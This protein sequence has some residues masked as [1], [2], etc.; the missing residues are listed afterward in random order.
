MGI[1]KWQ[2]CTSDQPDGYGS[3]CVDIVD[4]N[5]ANYQIREADLNYRLRVVVTAT[6]DYG[7]GTAAPSKV[8][9]PVTPAPPSADPTPPP[10]PPPGI[11]APEIKV[12][13]FLSGSTWTYGVELASRCE[14]QL[15]GGGIQAFTPSL[16]GQYSVTAGNGNQ[17]GQLK[18]WNGNVGPVT[19]SWAGPSAP[20]PPPPDPGISAP[21]IILWKFNTGNSWSYNVSNANYCEVVLAGGGVQP[22]SPS[23]G[24]QFSVTAGNG[25]QA[26]QLKCWNSSVGPAISAFDGPAAPT[27]VDPPPP[28]LPGPKPLPDQY[29]VI[30][31]KSIIGE[32]LFASSGSWRFSVNSFTYQ[33]YRCGGTD[34]L[35]YGINC[36]A[37][38]FAKNTSY[39]IDASDKGQRIVVK[40][41]ATNANGSVSVGSLATAVVT[42]GRAQISAVPAGVVAAGTTVSLNW[43]MSPA[44]RCNLSSNPAVANWNGKTNQPA[45]GSATVKVT[46][47]TVFGWGC[48]NAQNFYIGDY[49]VVVDNQQ[50]PT[51][52]PPPPPPPGNPPAPQPNL[53]VNI[54]AQPGT[55]VVAGTPVS[56]VWNSTNATSCTATSSP[57]NP[58]W[59]GSKPASGNQAVGALTATTSFNISCNGP[60]GFVLGSV[61]VTIGAAPADAFSLNSP[62]LRRVGASPGGGGGGTVAVLDTG[63]EAHPL[64]NV[65]GGFNCVAGDG[66]PAGQDDNGHGTSVAGVIGA[67]GDG[68]STPRGIAPGAAIISIKMAGASG[69]SNFDDIL[70]AIREG[71]ARAGTL[72]ISSSIGRLIING[73][74]ETNLSSC[75]S[76]IL[77]QTI[78]NARVRIVAAAGNSPNL[79]TLENSF[80]R[81]PE[82]TA[83]TAMHDN[84]GRPGALGS[85]T[86]GPSNCTGDDQIA[87]YSSFYN[88]MGGVIAAPG[89]VFTTARGGGMSRGSGGTSHATPMVAGSSGNASSDPAYMY[90]P[91]PTNRD[92]GPLLRL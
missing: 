91:P 49:T 16:G 80:G 75:D 46:E 12:W 64:L 31:G 85:A 26:G 81:Y 35:G 83:V 24:G 2:R 73:E 86:G 36:V 76:S 28:P 59:S 65:T 17:A 6:N 44:T 58:Q 47:T 11:P 62:H 78:C 79:G 52:P 68:I 18:C 37:I 55:T 67:S 15:Q 25:G 33:W 4:V 7:P 3:D 53:T 19:S 43:D 51:N 74:P 88:G 22:F 45:I 39:K 10:P 5:S 38:L 42:D 13:Q 82:V 50:P 90:Q 61:N 30:T 66:T 84:D 54:S 20:N 69:V 57:N 27:T 8:K 77:H 32:S 21:T 70:C 41:T 9:L 23:N 40:V 29:P 89:C 60:A 34:S 92:Y 48:S 71:A 87:S 72:N 1:Y 14:V 63:V 56:I